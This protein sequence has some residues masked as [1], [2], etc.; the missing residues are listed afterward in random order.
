M[1][2]GGND[3]TP[4]GPSGPIKDDSKPS[5]PAQEN[6]DPFGDSV[7]PQGQPQGD[8]VL[9]KLADALQDAQSAKLLEE[10]TGM[11]REKLEQFVK[12]YEKMKSSPAGPG[13]EIEVKPGEQTPA[14]PGSNLPG[15]DRSQRIKSTNRA[16]QDAMPEDTLR[17]MNEGVRSEP[18]PEWRDKVQGYKSRIARS[19]ATGKKRTAQ[20]TPAGTP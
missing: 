1:G 13:R 20:P 18:P 6:Q 2:G 8:L 9:G 12:A 10:R 19:K 15:F 4:G 3:Q 5:P 7:A 11:S 17:G 16:N 14:K